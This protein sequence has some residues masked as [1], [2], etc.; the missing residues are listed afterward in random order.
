MDEFVQ[1]LLCD[2]EPLAFLFHSHQRLLQSLC[3]KRFYLHAP[4]FVTKRV[5][6]VEPFP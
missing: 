2:F 6:L 1:V 3:E 4:R 5:P